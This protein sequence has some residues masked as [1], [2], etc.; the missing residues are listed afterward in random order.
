[1]K[2]LFLYPNFGGDGKI[3]I[4][5]ALLMTILNNEGHKI[6]LFDVSFIAGEHNHND[7]LLERIGAV[8]ETDTSHLYD[9]HTPSEIDDL[10]ISKIKNFS[11]DL[12]GSTIV[13]DN[14]K[15]CH[16]LLKIIK[17]IDP[18]IPTIVGGSTPS[19]AASVVIENPY[20]DY[21]IQGEAEGPMSEFCSLMEKNE[22]VTKTA[23]LWHKKNGDV[24]HNELAPLTNLDELPVMDWSW[25]DDAHLIKAY[26]GK[27][28]RSGRIEMSRGCP[29]KCTYCINE[30]WR[31]TFFETGSKLIRKKSVRKVIDEAK[32][33]KEK[34]NLDMFFFCDDNFLALTRDKMDEF[35]DLW[36][37]EVGLPFWINTTLESVTEW[38]L[39]A[40]S[41]CGCAGIGI[42]LESGN[43][44]F[45]N[46]ILKRNTKNGNEIL[47]ETFNLI[48]QH[49]IRATANAMIG[50]PGET[51][52]DM[53]ETIKMMKRIKPASYDITFVAPYIGT[54]IHDL[55]YSR[56][57]IDVDTKPGFV[58]MSVNIGFRRGAVIRNPYVSDKDMEDIVNNFF[59]YVTGRLPIPDDFMVEAPGS[60][61]TAP[62]RTESLEEAE[63]IDIVFLNAEKE[64]DKIRKSRKKKRY[65][66]IPTTYIAGQDYNR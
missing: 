4:G 58:N 2:I 8:K 47:I 45:R 3:P 12:V 60:S 22:D 59:D 37:E 24:H 44:W 21:L 9:Y 15:Y 55:A 36:K 51:K 6:E 40:L 54:P 65:D 1:M 48:K 41:E 46:H 25:W 66:T 43:E 52:A 50:F 33:L 57:L 32:F 29:Q 13:E 7:E 61:A 11:P 62:E 27:L 28:Y 26:E 49:G 5:M 64:K 23:S 42:G 14:Y 34:Y 63:F 17:T 19:I 20:I 53:F 30:T 56:G 35:R 31:N 18:E 16:R 39:A 38:R 10:L